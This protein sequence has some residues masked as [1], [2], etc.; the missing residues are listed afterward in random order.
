MDDLFYARLTESARAFGFVTDA[1]TAPTKKSVSSSK[2]DD[3]PILQR[4]VSQLKPTT[5]KRNYSRREHQRISKEVETMEDL[6]SYTESEIVAA[7]PKQDLTR[8]LD[9][10]EL[11]D[12]LN[13]T[14]E[15]MFYT[16]IGPK[17]YIVEDPGDDD[18]NDSATEVTDEYLT[19][20]GRRK[21][22]SV[23]K[24]GSNGDRPLT[25]EEAPQGT[26]SSATFLT[27]ID[28]NDEDIEVNNPISATEVSPEEAPVE[29]D[30]DLQKVFIPYFNENKVPIHGL[31]SY[32]PVHKDTVPT[33]TDGDPIGPSN[34]QKQSESPIDQNLLLALPRSDIVGETQNASDS[35]NLHLS[36]A[37]GSA[38]ENNLSMDIGTQDAPGDAIVETE[39]TLINIAKPGNQ[40]PISIGEKLSLPMIQTDNTYRAYRVN[41]DFNEWNKGTLLWFN[42]SDRAA[43]KFN[44][45]NSAS[46]S[47][48]SWF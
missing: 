3:K 4:R 13:Q 48:H 39:K 17:S 8:P 15:K 33:T 26:M 28:G 21:K 24:V 1:Q 16:M 40:E 31:P 18:P 37:S 27:T 29:R 14:E 45:Y 25:T 7:L 46:L 35:D 47:F 43:S 36:E 19:N 23:S 5:P 12:L 30:P 41:V 20:R 22:K 32:R 9:A 42:E 10:E 44:F 6:P 2:S 34:Q 38:T 11:L